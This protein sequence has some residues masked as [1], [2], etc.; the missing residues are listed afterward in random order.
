MMAGD[1]I[2]MRTDLADDPAVI[3]MTDALRTPERPWMTPQLVVGCW[4]TLWSWANHQLRDGCASGVTAVW[5]DARVGVTGFTAAAQHVGWLVFDG[6]AL[7]FPNWDR[8]NSKSAKERLLAQRRMANSRLR[9]RYGDAVTKSQPQ[10]RTEQTNNSPLTPPLEGGGTPDAHQGMTRAERKAAE[11]RR[12]L[13]AAQ[14]AFRLPD[15]V[16]A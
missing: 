10:Y 2:A 6:D 12:R 3:A 9:K 5:I 1:W 14:A 7:R 4:H 16:K 11:R 8:W 15:E 13:A